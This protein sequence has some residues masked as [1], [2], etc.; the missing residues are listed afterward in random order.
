MYLL[1]LSRSLSLSLFPAPS[2]GCVYTCI[3]Y[4]VWFQEKGVAHQTRPQFRCVSQ[5]VCHVT[6]CVS[7]H[8]VCVT[9]IALRRE[10]EARIYICINVYTY[11]HMY[12]YLRT[13]IHTY[14]YV[15]VYIYSYTCMFLC[16]KICMYTHMIYVLVCGGVCGYNMITSTVYVRAV[17]ILYQCDG[18]LNESSH[19]SGNT[20][21]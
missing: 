3:E 5:G 2:C 21:A 10:F 4:A 18:R 9:T 20:H 11:L 14:I 8:K 13:Y 1:S 7:C 16:K 15:Y 17:I 19:V 12:T 6:K